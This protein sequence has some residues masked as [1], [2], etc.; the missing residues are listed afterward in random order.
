MKKLLFL[1][2]LIPLIG[3]SQSTFDAMQFLKSKVFDWA[4]EPYAFGTSTQ[5]IQ[6]DLKQNAKNDL[7]LEFKVK[8]P[9]Y[10]GEGP[11]GFYYCIIE[12]SK[13]TR[14][15]A[16]DPANKCASIKIYTKPYGSQIYMTD[17]RGQTIKTI[18]EGNDLLKSLGWI[19][20]EIKIKT[21]YKYDEYSKRIINTI[22]FLAK[23]NGAVLEKSKF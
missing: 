13:I 7:F 10:S 22:E 16:M 11:K 9:E 3:S 18:N 19:I 6:F 4:C 8:L 21:D 5:R 15:E 2:F 1:L 12:L 14:V 17:S 20:S 23:E